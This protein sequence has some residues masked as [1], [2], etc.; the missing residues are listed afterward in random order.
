MEPRGT[1]GGTAGGTAG[2]TGGTTGTS[3]GSLFS[4]GPTRSLVNNPQNTTIVGLQNPDQFTQDLTVP[5]QQGSFNVGIPTF[6]GYNPNA[7]VQTGIAILSDLE[8]FF[9]IQA[10]QGDQRNN[11]LFA[12]KIT[13]FNGQTAFVSDTKARPFVTSLI[14]T[15]G[16]GAVGYTPVVTTVNEGGFV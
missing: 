15:V 7:G 13:L 3:T 2:T 9:F 14:P 4:P 8:A 11:L 1:T 5:F 16:I 10:A 6:G 12:P